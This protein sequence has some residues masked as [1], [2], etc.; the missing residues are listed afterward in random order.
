MQA[1]DANLDVFD[2]SVHKSPQAER[3]NNNQ[4]APLSE[5]CVPLFCLESLEKFWGNTL[6]SNRRKIGH[7][8]YLKSVWSVAILK[9]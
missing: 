8:K 7:A 6:S 2:L 4:K 3:D 9:A 1:P 5:H